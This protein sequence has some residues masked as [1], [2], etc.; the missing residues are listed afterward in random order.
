MIRLK[1]S[2]RRKL[3][4]FLSHIEILQSEEG[5]RFVAKNAGLGE[6]LPRMEFTGPDRMAIGNIV[7]SL[8]NWGTVE[9]QEALLL[10][11]LA[12]LGEV[13]EDR[14]K[15][16]QSFIDMLSDS[17]D[18]SLSTCARVSTFKTVLDEP[19]GE[20]MFS[21][22]KGIGTQ[23]DFV[24]IR[25]RLVL[26]SEVLKDPA[27][28]IEADSQ[29]Q[30]QVISELE[31]LLKQVEDIQTESEEALS[32]EGTS[33]LLNRIANNLRLCATVA[34]HPP[35]DG[36]ARAR[37]YQSV[38]VCLRSIDT[39]LGSSQTTPI[40]SAEPDNA[41]TRIIDANPNHRR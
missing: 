25:D 30:A 33:S 29:L 12:L 31:K 16:L 23:N 14:Q 9:G 40:T 24:P 13:G 35:R 20:S 26:Y 15:A 2:I 32:D 5:R 34:K 8:A 41:T 11:L 1:G 3:V 21:S 37:I 6:L 17:R 36:S 28:L 39:I 18:I 27:L 7:D 19:V 10:F 22:V 4:N 38:L